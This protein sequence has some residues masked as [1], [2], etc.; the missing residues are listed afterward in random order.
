M[1]DRHLALIAAAS[2]LVMALSAHVPAIADDALPFTVTEVARFDMPWAMTFLPNGDMLVTEKSGTMKWLSKGVSQD[3]AGMPKVDDEG[4]GSL[5]DILPAPD[6]ATSGNVYLSW[7]E[8]GEGGNGVAVGRAKLV[9][10]ANPRLDG[11]TVIWRQTKVA[12]AIYHYSQKLA[13]SPDGKYLFVTAGERNQKTPAQ[14]VKIN[15]GKILRLT[16]DGKPA[17][18]NPFAG[19]DGQAPEVWSYGHRNVYGL[20]FAPDGRLWENEMGPKGGDEV[21]LIVAGKNYGWPVVSNGSDY[22][23]ADIPNHATRPDFETPRLWWNPSISPS[24]LIIYTGDAFPQWKGDAFI[25]ALSG[26][27]L[28][29]VD[30]DGAKATKADQWDMETRVRDVE[31]GPDGSIYLLEDGEGRLLRLSPKG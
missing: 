17:Q 11:L 22:D 15:L 18:G 7:S 12:D 5:G 26:Q 31:Q 6:Y 3:I 23:D 30:I 16:L 14:D 2:S 24:S 29:R 8:P 28:I 27:V 4:Q 1:R 9:L 19:H 21:N 13:F 25:G 20:A 10:D